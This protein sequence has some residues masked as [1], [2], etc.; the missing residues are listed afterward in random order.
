MAVLDR[1]LIKNLS[2]LCRIHCTDEEIEGL[3]RDLAEIVEYFEQ[4]SE[5]DTDDV[6]PCN[7]VLDMVNVEREDI[8]GETI[9]REVFLA[10][11]PE[12]VGGMVRVPP[13]IKSHQS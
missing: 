10:N 2:M 13:V 7:H 3:L 1:K 12:H 5:I 8:P 9:P 4:L 11:A 6:A